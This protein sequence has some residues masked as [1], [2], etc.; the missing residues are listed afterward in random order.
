MTSRR[1]DLLARIATLYYYQDLS[2]QEIAQQ[3]GISRSNVSRL[4]KEAREQG[5]VE[6]F[7]HYPIARVVELERQIV[8]RF[9]LRAAGVVETE[10]NDP[11]A[12]LQRAAQLAGTILD[13]ALADTQ[14]LGISWGTT[15]HAV[16]DSFAPR[17]RHDVEVVQLMGGIP[18][19]EPTIDGPALAQRLARTLTGRYRYLHAPLVVDRPEVVEALLSQR[20]IAEA[21]EVAA[22]A[23]VALVGIGAVDSALSSLL[24]AGYLSPEEFQSMRERGAVG[25]LCARH[26]DQRGLPV[27]PDLDARLM[28]IRL[29]QLARIPTVIGAAC[30][31]RKAAAIRGALRGGFLDILVTDADTAE[32]VLL[33]DMQLE[34]QERE[35][36]AAL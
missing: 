30:S 10:L 27:A 2:Q 35:Q 9:G 3:I 4:L 26:F 5:V 16:I 25:D 32:A 19:A 31:T 17:R 12:T 7:I 8:E 29:D 23:E 1:D 24:R 28:A 20:N 33:L 21:L 6:I 15:V 13:D 14:T 22:N 11:T 34:R 36:I 18:S